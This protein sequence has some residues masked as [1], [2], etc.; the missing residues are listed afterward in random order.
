[1]FFWMLETEQ[2]KK[3]FEKIYKEYRPLLYVTANNILQ[4]NADAED[5]VQSCFLKLAEKYHRYR[6]LNDEEMLRLCIV[7][8]R[9][10]AVDILREYQKVAY[11]SEEES[12][13]EDLIPDSSPEISEQVIKR[14]EE[15]LVLRGMGQL[16][17]KDRQFLYLHYV[18]GLK[19]NEIGTLFG[20]SPEAVRQKMHRSRSNLAKQLNRDEFED[21]RE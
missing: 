18:L 11:F 9:N 19:M 16:N 7:I 5:A 12:F 2:E 3:S 20:M 17:E 4:N 10:K 8:V 1:M 13:T 14:H 21:H 15:L 6:K